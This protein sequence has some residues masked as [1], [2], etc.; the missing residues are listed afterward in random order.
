MPG[1]FC[2]LCGKSIDDNAP[3][4]SLCL[5]CYLKENPLF[6]LPEKLHIKVCLDCGQYSRKE[7]W[8]DSN[9]EDIFKV[10]E[11]AGHE[12]LLKEHEKMGKLAFSLKFDEDSYEFSSRDLLKAANLRVYGELKENNDKH[13]EQVIRITIEYDLCKNCS[14]IR[15]GSFFISILQLR[16]NSEEHMKL[17]EDAFIFI[18]NFSKKEKEKE[19]KNY[20]AKVDEQKYGIDIYLSSNELL[21]HLISHLKTQYHFALTRSKKLVGRDIQKGKNIYRL[22]ALI[23]FLPFKKGDR[24]IL[25]ENEY[26]IENISKKKVVFRNDKNQRYVEDYSFFFSESLKIILENDRD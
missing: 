3:H 22:K 23:R 5:E 24:I 1:R 2:A 18:E 12:F 9:Q 11:D 17:I 6:I 8:H 7:E 13:Y 26:I 4:F 10:V 25:R 16:V 15:T 20:I 21:N 19:P 14:N